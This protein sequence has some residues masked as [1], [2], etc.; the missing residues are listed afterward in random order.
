MQDSWI[1][2]LPPLVV[3]L[4]AFLTKKVLSSLALG[5]V[6]ASFIIA[7]FN[8]LKTVQTVFKAI[9]D[10]LTNL[11]NI[12][13]FLFLIALG[14]IISL[15]TLTGG[16]KAYARIIKKRIRTARGA[17]SASILLSTLLL[18]DDFFSS[19][20]VGSIMKPL[21]D[22]FSIPRAKLAFL[23]DSM[24]APLVVIMPISSWIAT[25]T[26]QLSKAGVS[27]NLQDH[28]LIASEPFSLYL[29]IIPFIFYSFILM[30]SV[31]FIVQFRISFGPMRRHEKIAKETGNLFGG[32]AP[33]TELI[34]EASIHKGSVIDFIVPISTLLITIFLSILFAGN[35]Y[36]FG[37][38][39]SLLHAVQQTNIF[40]AL[41]LGSTITLIASLL[42]FLLSKKINLNELPLVT[43]SGLTLMGSSIA[44]LFCS[45]TFSN[46]LLVDLQSGHY[47]AHLMVGNI[48][49][50][51]LPCI[52]F[53]TSAIT[54]IA[55]GSSW[56]TIAIMVPLAVPMLIQFFNA[57]IPSNPSDIPLIFPLLGAIFAGAVAGDHI[58]PL[59][60]T[61]I[62]SALS[63][64]SHLTHHIQTQVA[65]A[66][67]SLIASMVAY[68]IAGWLASYNIFLSFFVSLFVGIMLCFSILLKL[69]FIDKKFSK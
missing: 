57:Q 45:W 15:I 34:E 24:A 12:Y 48:N 54:S 63:S 3:L 67:P 21:T 6:L 5:I 60:S 37:G 52:F 23:I 69:N 51:L 42:F 47:L 55:I 46:L 32:K 30:A 38:N 62:M 53:I 2:L 68:L 9:L 58:S 35:Y 25:L 56:G 16:T 43:H 20:T 26:M 18:F 36:L 65:Y 64:G 44:I 22:H 28:P 59:S 40:F 11:D 14:I 41:F 8:P 33:T 17:E 66:I 19:I 27:A 1:V 10:Q 61:T 39:N 50:I 7:D 4:T 49:V 13:I 29:R 31:I